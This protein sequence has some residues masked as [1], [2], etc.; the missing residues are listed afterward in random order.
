MTAKKMIISRPSQK[1]GQLLTQ[2]VLNRDY[3]LVQGGLLMVTAL[4]VFVNV[5][6]DVSYALLDPRVRYETR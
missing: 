3:P 5:L 2:A 1:F 4:L 6:V